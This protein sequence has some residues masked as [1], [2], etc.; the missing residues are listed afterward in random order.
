[1]DNHIITQ[2]L[3]LAIE[4]QQIPAPTFNEEERRSFI[5]N[6]F[7]K[8]GLLDTTNDRIGNVYARI[9]GE[10]ESRPIVISAHM[11]TVFP[12]DTDLSVSR[13]DENISGPGIGDNSLGVAGLFGLLWSLRSEGE[14]LPGDLWL[15]A[16][17]CEEGLGDL[18]GMRAVIDRF[19]NQPKAYIILE[20]LSYGSVYHRGL[21]VRR[22]RISTH[23]PG[24]HS[25]GDYGT[26]SAIH[27]MASLINKLVSLP[28]SKHPPSSINVG[29][30]T[31][32]TT[33]NTIAANAC[34]E[35]DLRSEGL[36]QLNSLVQGV[37]VLVEEANRDQVQASVELIGNR[38]IGGISQDHPLVR[39]AVES[40]ENQGAEVKLLSGSTDANLPLS[41]DFPAICIGMTTGGGAHTT[42]EFINTATLKQGMEHIWDVVVGAFSL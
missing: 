6:K 13:T 14:Q 9:P 2:V 21:G 5:L 8:E 34:I 11:D 12:L 37:E 22:Y 29:V 36:R 16:N 7:K 25:W 41:H 28:I 38:P 20:G 17:S 24:G 39:L 30:I 1:M 27:E 32:G 35:L 26:P 4:I 33:V 31:G 10:G 42:S 18:K 15:V 40:L 19:R 3:E 23:T